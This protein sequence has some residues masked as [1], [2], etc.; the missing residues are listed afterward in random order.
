MN[1][2]PDIIW[3]YCDEL[4]TDALGCYGNTRI[5]PHTPNLDRLA[6]SGVRF[7]N[8]FCNAPVCVASR[9]STLSGL[10]PEDTGVYNNEGAWPNFRLP[11]RLNTFP[12][13]FAQNGYTTASF[14]KTHVPPEM[15]HGANPDNELFQIYDGSGA[16]C[17]S[18][19]HS[20]SRACG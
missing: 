8:N 12:H 6:Q 14:G 16:T 4:R 11:R 5:D 13:V 2:Q 18:G 17:D 19:R 9:C 15:R 1:D 7:T 3:I 20:A 10:Y